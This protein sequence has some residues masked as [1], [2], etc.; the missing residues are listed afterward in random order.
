MSQ[1]LEAPGAPGID[2][3]WTSST[4]SGIGKA[5]NSASDVTFTLS[6]GIL[7]E[8]YYPRED[9]AS[10]RDMGFVV[11]DGHEFFSEEK[12]DTEH[13]IETIKDGIPAYRIVNTDKFGKFQITKE[14]IVDPF[15]NTILQHIVFDQ[16]DPNLPLRLFA[17][18]APH[19]N[20]EGG[21]NTGW[22]GEYKGVEMLFAKN[23]STA[24]AMACS[25]KWLKRSVGYVGKSDGWRDIRQH[26]KLEWEYD[27]AE[28]GNI[29]LTG[30]IDLSEKDFVLAISF[31][32]THLEAAN[33]A[34]ASILNGFDTAKRKYIQEW[35]TWQN[36]LPNI[37]AE[38]FKMSAAILR[39]HEAKNFPGGIIASLS[40]PWGGT[41][42]D[43]DKSG[44]H[45][46]WPRD[47]VQTA[48]GFNALETKADVSRIV[49]YLMSTQNA[50]GSW[51]QNMWLQGEPNWYGLQMDQIALPIL[52]ILKGY[53][54]NT[55]SNNRMIRYWPLAKKAITFLLV[56]GPF[57]DQDRWEE[58]SGF[59][60]FTMATE[61]A[62]LLAGA[63][64]AE[65]NG[66]K[67]FAIYCRDTADSWNDTIEYRTY[68]TGTPLAQK[69]GVDGYYI[70]INPFSDIPAAELGNRTVNLKNHHSDHGKT[71]INEL[72]SVDA[73]ALVRFG[74]RAA[75]DP[76]ILNTLK[77]IDAELKVATSNGDCW[78]RYNNDGYG[79]QENGDPYD[80]TGKGRAWPLLTGERGHYE[81]AAGNIESANK[82]LK[83]MEAFA[84]HGLIPEQIW[85]EDDIPE[86]G[87]RNGEHT[88]S[89]MPLTW[90]HAEY[91]KLC[92]SIEHK[93]VFDMPIET[94]ERYLKNKKKS[95]NTIWR[96]DNGSRTLPKG[97][98]L[99]I[100]TLAECTVLWTDD[101]WKTT[102]KTASK[103]LN[104]GVFITDIKPKEEVATKIE[105]TF[106]WKEIDKWEGKNYSVIVVNE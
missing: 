77:I 74:L 55:M 27:R 64:L 26:G 51:P 7:N 5:L 40:I 57:T 47:L 22:L 75:D 100:E 14:V 88:G 80:G 61:I 91:I 105:F 39:M 68:V 95:D 79:E 43:A 99:R 53:L 13:F 89:A 58:E 56:N 49:N 41:K 33:H 2:A 104:F 6:H 48:G 102:F 69:H 86:K 59:S 1:K 4:K 78:Y 98:T 20:N 84:N 92:I 60:P 63:E 18:L 50:D 16:K 90:A 76:K 25:S 29:A 71:N 54:R 31:G 38:N 93:K 3:R 35:Q 12:R 17:L 73:L 65:I 81:I 45:V 37:H 46:V 96:F 44:Y 52:E 36:T 101:D 82:R 23:G 106:Y 15:R 8:A 10:I 83:A 66:D 103:N 72:I 32:I 67:D 87:L 24:L 21:N 19:L 9:I 42:G 70:R 85:D 97:K 34:R 94:H 28:K 11:T 62:A 30:E